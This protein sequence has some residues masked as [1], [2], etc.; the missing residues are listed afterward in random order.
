[1][2]LNHPETIPTPT[3][4]AHGNTVFP[5]T[6]FWCQKGWGLLQHWHQASVLQRLIHHREMQLDCLHI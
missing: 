6:G 1:M 5:R 2:H 3:P 4:Q